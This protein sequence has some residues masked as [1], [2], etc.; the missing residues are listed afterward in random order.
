MTIVHVLNEDAVKK[1]IAVHLK[2]NPDDITLEPLVEERQDKYVGT[3]IGLRGICV[4]IN[5]GSPT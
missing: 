4:N 3:V 2:A 1:L 5:K